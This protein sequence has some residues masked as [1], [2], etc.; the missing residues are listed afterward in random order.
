M[1]TDH[2]RLLVPSLAAKPFVGAGC[3]VFPA[4][5]L[6]CDS[7]REVTGV[8]EVACDTERGEI[9]LAFD[10]DA[11]VMPIASGILDGLG[12]PVREVRG[13]VA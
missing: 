10:A 8:R 3:C 5:E 11:D 9:E 13:V 1:R 6:I 7:L 4:D 2:R 12:Y